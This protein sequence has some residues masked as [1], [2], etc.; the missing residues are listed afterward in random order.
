VVFGR[1]SNEVEQL[2]A[3]E[4]DLFVPMTQN[5]LESLE[6]PLNVPDASVV[7]AA[8]VFT[9]PIEYDNE[10]YTPQVVGIT[11]NYL[12]AYNFGIGI[13]E[14][15]TW[16]H[17]ESSARVAVIGLDV[18]EETFNGTYPIGELIRI[19]GVNFEVIGVW[20]EIESAIDPEANNLVV[21]PIS[22]VQQRLIGE[23][24]LDGSYPVTSISVKAADA[25]VVDAVVEQVRTTLRA[26]RDLDFDETDTFVVFSQNELLDI[27][28]TTTTLL[29]AFLGTIAGI[30]LLVGGIG[31]MNIM[32]VTVTERTREI[33]V[34]KAMGA[35]RADILTQFLIEAITLALIGGGIGT[36]IAVSLS[37]LAT[38]LLEGLAVTVSYGSIILATGIS[39]AI[40]VFFG[41]YPANRAAGLNPIDALRYE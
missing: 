17:V 40:G 10:L 7:A 23:R 26:E 35:Q 19:N 13:G 38:S 37:L 15:L 1:M 11:P 22:T 20:D 25:E 27:L 6:N 29:T 8:I 30:S 18:V 4:N 16:D 12:E 34:R 21:L 14:P 31:I 41:V 9:E 3:D 24:T 28:G 39:I 33:G 2:G 36:V 5:D 32:L